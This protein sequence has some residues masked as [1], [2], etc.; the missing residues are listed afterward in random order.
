MLTPRRVA[1]HEQQPSTMDGD[2]ALPAA[3]TAHAPVPS[4]QA[5]DARAP[6]ST[7]ALTDE[8]TRETAGA[9]A[10]MGWAED[11]IAAACRRHPGHADT[12]YHAFSLLRPRDIDALATEFVYRSHAAELL[13]R[14]AAGADTRP[15]T[16]AE[17]CAVSAQA[18]QRVP[19]H[20]VAAGL[21]F[22]MWQAAFP[23][24]PATAEHAEQ[25]V[26]YESLYGAQIDDLEA[27]LRHKAADPNRRLTDVDCAGRHHGRTVA[28][29]YADTNT[30]TNTDA[31]ADADAD[32]V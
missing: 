6:S 9:F 27:E 10:M 19:M 23:A 7:A 16:A 32:G 28:C 18:S 22:R 14:L 21:Y 8:L 2:T 5:G 11:E 20:G 13:D 15:A 24:H 31:D 3:R 29:R 25:Q 17:V 30:N 4:D 26:H 12:L 1:E